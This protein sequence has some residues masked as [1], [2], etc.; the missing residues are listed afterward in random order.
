MEPFIAI[1]GPTAVGK[2]KL[3]FQLAYTF[4][5]EIVS[6][7]SRQVYRYM[8]I[9]T[10]K[11]SPELRAI[12]PH[13]V[14]DI[15]DPDQP[16]NLAFY[17]QLACEA[18]DDIQ[19][20]GK[21]AILV[22]GSGLYAWSVIEGW[23][24]PNVPPQAETRRQLE[25]Q[26]A[27][28]G[29]IAL[30]RQLQRAAPLTASRIDPHNIRRLIRA[31]E[32]ARAGV[33]HSELGQKKPPPFPILVIGLTT[34]R[35]EL[36][37]MID[38]RVDEMI[39]YGLVAETQSLVEKGYGFDLPAMSGLGYKQIGL[40]LQGKID[41]PAAIQRIKFETHRFAR[42]QYAWFRLRDKRI[43][44]FDTEEVIERL[45]LAHQNL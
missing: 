30:Y 15:V 23:Q 45:V 44:W 9:G 37:K 3:A 42:H 32:I 27:K 5:G 11:P 31:L 17:Q 4:D 26:A 8:D 2:S 6:A 39:N 38:S 33:P 18:I 21:L 13:H 43:S 1:V 20:R 22:G 41:L 19:R 35:E 24:I 16:L 10:A 25:Q 7:D 14:I 12:V 36:Y 28:E 40:Y 29:P 34:T